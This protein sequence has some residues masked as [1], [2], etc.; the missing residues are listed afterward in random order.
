MLIMSQKP[1]HDGAIAAVEN[2]TLLF[3][4]EAEKD[5][6]PRHESV[7]PTLFTRALSLLPRAPDV[8]AISGWVKGWHSIEQPLAAG[9]FGIAEH[10]SAVAFSSLFGQ[11]IKQFSSTHER[12]HLLTAYGMSPVPQGTPCYALVWEG[13]IGSFYEIDKDVRIRELGKVLEDPGNKFSFCFGLADP[14]FPE[15]RG[16]FRFEDAG[17]LMALAGFADAAPISDDEQQ[18]IDYLL[19]RKSILLST[20]KSE[21]TWTPYYNIGVES[22]AFKNLAGKLSN[23]IFDKFWHFAKDNMKRRLPL[24]IAGGCGLN[25]EWNSRWKNCGL[26]PEVFVPPCPNDSGSAIGT[27]VD[28]LRHFTGSAKLNWSVYA[29]DEF[30]ND[31]T[32]FQGYDVS[33]LDYSQVARLLNDG[34]VLGWVQGKYEIGPR[35]LGHRSIIASPLKSDML[36]R[37]NA[38]KQRES[39]RPIAPVCLEE[40]VADHFSWSGPSPHMLYFQKVINEALVAVTHA[41]QSS[42]VQTISESQQPQLYSLLS[43]FKKISGH[44]VLCNTSLNFKGRGFINRM[45]D[46]L[47]YAD[48]RKLDGFIV[49]STSYIRR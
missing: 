25:C 40:D 1:G 36:C 44:G 49:G 28:A 18:L 30:E 42:R 14:T 16:H 9:Y 47:R 43:A 33:P 2:G 3:C 15:I 31:C 21:M 38:I 20:P 5:S 29:G 35:A 26:F 24:L 19:S 37:L 8:W 23:A 4:L 17:K 13:N 11:Q 27:A 10:E 45:S 34:C 41:D 46:L 22:Q 32:S 12:S 7:T 39:Y 6:F 48:D